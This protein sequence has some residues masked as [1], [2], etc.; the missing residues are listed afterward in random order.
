M[1]VSKFIQAV[2]DEARGRP[3]STA[4]YK[5]KIKEFGKPGALNLIRDGK[6]NNKPFYG[7]L[8]MFFY[9]PKF[10]KTLPYYDVFPLVLPLEI[11]SDGFLGINLHYL[12]I[13]LRIKLL[14]KLV[15]YSNNT[16]FDESTKLMVDY[17]KLK[18]I[19]LI[20]PTIHKY[21]AGQ[22]KSQFR[23]IDA[24]EFTIATLLPVQRF[25]KASDRE[26]WKESRSM[27]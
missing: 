6:R 12:P 21:L 22:T 8:N 23:R 19:N 4:W 18:R 3:R 9:D 1:A 24:D 2:K 26:V 27:I 10:K 14:D 16:K 5:E 25:K 17:K 11:Y 20:K 13:P 7:R 15:D